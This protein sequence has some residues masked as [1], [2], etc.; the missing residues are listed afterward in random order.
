MARSSNSGISALT[1]QFG[2]FPVDNV[3]NSFRK[4][5]EVVHSKSRAS[6]TLLQRKLSNAWL[7]NAIE[8]SP[9][10]AGWWTINIIDMSAVIDFDSKNSEHLKNA[11]IELMNIV[12]EWDVIAPKQKRATW[13]ASVLFPDVEIGVGNIRYRISEQ[14]REN[15]LRPEI[16]ALIDLNIV[17]R[18]RRAPSLAIYEHC[19][20]FE[21]IGRTTEVP[22][23]QFRD[24]VLGASSE[25]KIYQ[26]YKYFKAKVLTPCIAEVNAESDIT[27]VLKE[28]KS[29]RTVESLQFEVAKK[30]KPRE[31]LSLDESSLPLI[32]EMVKLGVPQSEA[33]RLA[34]QHS[35]DLI[36]AALAYTKNRLNDKKNAKLAKPAAYFRRALSEGWGVVDQ[37]ELADNAADQPARHGR[38]SR[39]DQIK[40]AFAALRR[41]EAEQY[42]RELE[43]SDQEQLMSRYNERQEVASLKIKASKQ[44][45]ATAAAF[46]QWLA[47]DTW[48]EPTSDELLEFAQRM[49]LQQG[50]GRS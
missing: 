36:K 26:E 8:N 34:G 38:Q 30:E 40:E 28:T 15:I 3:P 44:T 17:R 45:K 9:D 10:D 22:W 5:V 43:A 2:L 37:D 39:G 46:Y 13:K 50:K 4:A 42:F 24:I 14:I 35:A 7:K 1:Q 21:K 16:Y 29:G 12:F 33:K 6:L 49:L 25:Q 32:G 18:F 23:R 48:G 19:T 11:A 31:A 27:I 41:A 20:R 47:I